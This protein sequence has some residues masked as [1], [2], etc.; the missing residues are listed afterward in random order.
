MSLTFQF[1][2]VWTGL[3]VRFRR[4]DEE[5]EDTTKTENIDKLLTVFDTIDTDHG[6][7]KNLQRTSP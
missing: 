6:M 4:S 5:R 2:L 1:F 7:I 3:L